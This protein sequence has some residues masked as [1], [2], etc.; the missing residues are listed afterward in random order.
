[1]SLRRSGAIE[2]RVFPLRTP[3][4]LLALA[5]ISAAW[6][7]AAQSQ[8]GVRQPQAGTGQPHPDSSGAAREVVSP[9]VTVTATR[10]ATAPADAP[11]RVDVL[12]RRDAEAA[13]AHSLADLLE[14]RTGL[15]VK[16]YGPGGLAS[17]SL[18]GTTASQTLVLLDG[19]RLADPQLGQLDLSLL[20]AVLFERAEVLYGPGSAL[21]GT[22]GV[23]G[24]VHLRTGEGAPGLTAEFR[25]GA[26]GERGASVVARGA[27]TFRAGRRLGLLAVADAQAYQG[28]FGFVDSTRFNNETGQM[29]LWV[30]REGTDERR[31]SAFARAWLDAGALH[32]TAGA[33]GAAAERGLFTPSA[34]SGQRQWDRSRRVWASAER[35]AG[36]AVWHADAFVQDALLAW[37]GGPT[38][39]PDSGV[40]RT[41]SA[42]IRVERPLTGPGRVAWQ[43]TTGM[44]IGAG[45]A[46]H[47]SLT[48]GA[49]ER[50][51]ALFASA[52]VAYGRLR[53]YPAVRLDAVRTTGDTLGARTLTS[54]SPA[55]GANVRL[56]GPLR[57][58]ASARR[59]FRAPT[60]N[61]R[62]WGGAG[63]P[64]LRPE[65]AWTLDAGLMVAAGTP[66]AGVDAEVT[67]FGSAVRDQIV[68]R[69]GTD[70]VWRPGNVGRVRTD[71]W[72]ASVGLRAPLALGATA[73]LDAVATRTDA[74]DRSDPASAIYDQ[75]L[76]Y[77]PDRQLKVALSLGGRR[78]A[79]DGEVVHTGRR[80]TAADG[81]AWLAPTTVLAAGVR[82]GETRADGAIALAVRVENLTN[83]R[84]E[85]VRGYPMPPRHVSLRLSLTTR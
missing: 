27:H 83:L 32:L 23:G 61:D 50:S 54:L 70:A 66:A 38:V 4:F 81:S 56:V 20:P 64:D 36:A 69:P 41:M 48:A 16:R 34:G 55:L 45:R 71:G 57:I 67:R 80:H 77:V 22:D 8:A 30:R 37:A 78:L 17:A 26:F 79:A 10:V 74:R 29:G 11:A 59:A 52:V 43:T 9:G 35:R 31:A 82:V 73:R 75:P 2:A 39:A 18:R 21:Y 3:S 84:Y 14:A 28:D 12:D 46:R 44:Q 42:S 65:R 63:D 47:P 40:T 62:F 68:W 15:F 5:A 72:E 6:P 25:G 24:V 58:K 53:L 33:W 49:A 19:H 1:M 76:L 51:A 60:F 85:V 13:G 7:A